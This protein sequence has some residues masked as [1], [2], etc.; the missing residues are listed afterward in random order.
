[1]E[2][3]FP[4]FGRF[5][6]EIRRLIW[7]ATLPVDDDEPT[8]CLFGWRWYM[9][10]LDA[11]HEMEEFQGVDHTPY[12][13]VPLPAAVF[14][15]REAREVVVPWI[16]RRNLTMRL[17]DET[18]GHVLVREWDRERD[19]VYVSLHAWDDFKA[20]HQDW[21]TGVEE[22]GASIVHLAL[23]A[24]TAYFSIETLAS[25][26]GWMPNLRSVS[27]IWGELPVP[28]SSETARPPT[29]PEDLRYEVQV[30]PRWELEAE[31]GEMVQLCSRD[32]GGGGMVLAPPE[33]LA[34]YRDDME[35]QWVVCEVPEG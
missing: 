3:S 35:E 16:A 14:V 17:R 30:Q 11:S 32:P 2:N 23:P 5:P 6:P 13:Q 24:F 9:Q 29:A 34:G 18:Q 27:V 28:R 25:L 7:E 21:D 19:P 8:L 20:L 22:L 26:L 1:M 10:F 33:E 15:C 31:D 12:I 4:R